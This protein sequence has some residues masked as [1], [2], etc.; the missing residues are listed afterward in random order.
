MPRMTRF[1][2]RL[3]RASVRRRRLVLAVW[4]LIAI[5]VVAIGQASGGK[6][7][8][9][10]EISGVEAQTAL[11]VLEAKFPA[12]AGTSAQL[13]F[14]V[15]RG[16]L[17]DAEATAAVNAAL[18]DVAGQP[19]VES[20]GTL[21]RAE[22]NKIA[23]ADVQYTR[24]SS[25][26]KTEAFKRLEATA[27][28]AERSG[29]VQMELGGDLPSQAENAAPGGTEMIGLLVAVVVLLAAFGSVI[30]MGLP[31][32]LALVGLITSLGLITIVASF[33]DVNSFSPTLATMIGLGVGID[34]ALF[35]V[36]R[37]REHLH[38]GMTVEESAGRAIATITAT[39]S[40]DINP[41]SVTRRMPA[42]ARPAIAMTTVVPANSTARPAVSM[43][44]STASRGSSP[45]RRPLRKRVR[46]NSA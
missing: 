24:P 12:A 20:V 35:I 23:Y 40:P 3:G 34:Y 19:A 22:G 27:A 16:T 36:T 26:I 46:M 37:H 21:H 18:A 13:V 38:Q 8:E 33:V 9:T 4:L 11:D 10:F 25:E 5:G 45:S 41:M 2:Y 6:T 30:A 42:M 29:A 1:L 14:A 28:T 15:D 31:I 7:S 43:D 39:V 32:G 17:A 44:R